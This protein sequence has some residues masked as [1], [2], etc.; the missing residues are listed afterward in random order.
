MNEILYYDLKNVNALT[1]G[2]AAQVC[3]EIGRRIVGGYCREG[4]L[5]EDETKLAGR[6]GVSKS[7]IREAVKLLVGKGLL[8]V[9]R[10]SGT[11]VRPRTSWA[12]LDD[13][14]L[15]WHLS[16]DIK[17]DFLRQLMEIRR[18]M[19][20]KAAAWAAEN[21]TKAQHQKICEA[22][23]RM[24]R[25]GASAEDYVVA[26]AE[27][28]RAIFRAANNEILRS[29]EGVIFSALLSSIRLT[30]ADPRDNPQSIE[31][32]REVLDAILA[33]DAGTAEEKMFLHL[34][35]T[36]ERL[37]AALEDRARQGG[38]TSF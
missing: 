19:E 22:Q 28:H 36:S 33:R 10:G 18:V 5:I 14:V 26:D 37:G 11:R 20:P 27:F 6:Y 32:H 34:E 16:V 30:N 12:L 31:F 8:E 17:P 13:D 2:L 15:A 9:R 24:E 7:V 29:M 23:D 4:E 25:S 21:G 38:K 3:R 1:P 35:N